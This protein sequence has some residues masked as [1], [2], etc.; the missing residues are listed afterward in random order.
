[1]CMPIPN[2]GLLLLQP[3]LQRPPH[4]HRHPHLLQARLLQPRQQPARVPAHQQPQRCKT[5]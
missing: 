3:A 5:L 2:G 4:Q 1:M